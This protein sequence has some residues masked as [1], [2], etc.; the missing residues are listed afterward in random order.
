MNRHPCL[1]PLSREHHV[2]LV[3]AA[4]AKNC[5]DTPESVNEY[6]Q[7]LKLYLTDQIPR[8][9]ATEQQKIADVV[10]ARLGEGEARTLM[11][12]MLRQHEQIEQM[13]ELDAPT[14]ADVRA[15]AVLLHD[16]I[17]LEERQVFNLAQELMTEEELQA[18]YRFAVGA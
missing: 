10:L 4:K 1:Q 18:A 11:L 14:L 17:R 3:I 7:K 15:L 16:H 8:H 6:W 2:G 13:L 5:A 9:F 12:E